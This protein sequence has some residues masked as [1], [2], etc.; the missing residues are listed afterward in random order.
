MLIKME[1]ML[2]GCYVKNE[3]MKIW[4]SKGKGEERIGKPQGMLQND[5]ISVIVSRHRSKVE[6]TIELRFLTSSH[7]PK[8]IFLASLVSV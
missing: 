7:G 3:N 4:M 5:I 8:I 1:E 2:N 6:T